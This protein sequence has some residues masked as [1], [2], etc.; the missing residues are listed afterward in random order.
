M[1]GKDNGVQA[2]IRRKYPQATFVHC[3][4]HKLNIVVND[5]NYVVNVG[6]TCGTIKAILKYFR[7]SPKHRK[8][9]PNV[10][11]LSETSKY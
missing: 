3:A 11:M 9:I 5:L 2:R 8:V 4:S 7:D 6:N 1:A 10:P